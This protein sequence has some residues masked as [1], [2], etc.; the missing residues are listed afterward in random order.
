MKLHQRAGRGAS[1][2]GIPPC[3][4]ALLALVLAALLVVSAGCSSSAPHA[5]DRPVTATQTVAKP[6]SP[7]VA[8]T[9]VAAPVGGASLST[10]PPLGASR[11]YTDGMTGLYV[12]A[13][14]FLMG[15]RDDDPQSWADETPRHKVTLDAY[16]IDRT[17]VTNVMYA[18]C[19]QAGV[20]K[21]P[22][23]SRSYTRESYFGNP[24]YENY[25]VIYVSWGAA[26]RYCQW[27]G[28]R[29]PTE[30][31]WE[32]A[33]RGTT[34][35]RYPWGNQPPDATRGNGEEPGSDTAAVG[36]YPAGISPYGALDMTGNVWEWISD[37]YN[38]STLALT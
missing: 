14:A 18:R 38:D 24:Q 27:A 5:A 34:G 35:Q 31:E 25:P 11:V 36:S 10:P 12:P 21:A 4:W 22:K 8:A 6:V 32:K 16:W 29:L 17:E 30:A 37:W 15:S 26:Y 33:A 9:D 28:R 13:G 1:A 3:A 23:L 7:T 20:C 2:L 19:V